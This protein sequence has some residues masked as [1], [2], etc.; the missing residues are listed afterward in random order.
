[1]FFKHPACEILGRSEDATK[2]QLAWI[3][4]LR[5]SVW[6]KIAFGVR[7]SLSAS[8]LSVRR[9]SYDAGSRFSPCIIRLRCNIHVHSSICLALH[10]QTRLLPSLQ[11]RLAIIFQQA[12]I[13]LT[14]CQDHRGFKMYHYNP[15]T[16]AAAISIILSIATSLLHN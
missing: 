16:A 5:S 7:C 9:C 12:T 15:S 13:E 4:A 1:L 10:Q 6:L 2:Q 8:H 14:I 3:R 11:I